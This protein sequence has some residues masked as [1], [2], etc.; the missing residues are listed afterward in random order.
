[1]YEQYKLYIGLIITAVWLLYCM[2]NRLSLHKN[3]VGF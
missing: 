3:Q 2:M 1:M